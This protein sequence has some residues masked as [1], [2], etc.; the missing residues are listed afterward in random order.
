MMATGCG[1][2][3]AHPAL[4]GLGRLIVYLNAKNE[5]PLSCPENQVSVITC[6]HSV[7]RGTHA[8]KAQARGARDHLHLLPRVLPVLP[9]G[10]LWPRPGVRSMGVHIPPAFDQPF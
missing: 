6:P 7:E 2:W 1:G 4:L 8:L 10:P 9:R 3:R 5:I